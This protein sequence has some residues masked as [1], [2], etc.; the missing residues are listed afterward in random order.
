MSD[1]KNNKTFADID[2]KEYTRRIQENRAKNSKKIG[3]FGAMGKFFLWWI[4]IGA[5]FMGL[6]KENLVSH[7]ETTTSSRNEQHHHTSHSAG[8]TFRASHRTEPRK[9]TREEILIEQMEYDAIT[10]MTDGKGDHDC[11]CK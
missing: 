4:N 8:V 3:F 9:R 7:I 2:M 1:P 5:S 10:K 11:N 6:D